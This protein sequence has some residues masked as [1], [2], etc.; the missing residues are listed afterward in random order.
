MTNANITMWGCLIMSQIETNVYW[1]LAF[2]IAGA[3]SALIIF[4]DLKE[5]RN[6]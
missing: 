5:T 6:K 2:S 3:I 4:F 1:S